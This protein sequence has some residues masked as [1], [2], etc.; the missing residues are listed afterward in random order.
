V[1][2]TTK[3]PM[4]TV[5]KKNGIQ[6]QSPTSI[7]SHMDSIHSP[8]KTRNT[9]INECMKSVKFHLGISLSGKRSTLSAKEKPQFNT[10][11]SPFFPHSSV[12]QHG[13][14]PPYSWD[15]CITH[16]NTPQSV[17]LDW[18]SDQWRIDLYPTTLATDKHPCPQ[19][20]WNLD[21]SRRAA[22][23]LSLTSCGHWDR[24]FAICKHKFILLS[25]VHN[26]HELKCQTLFYSG[27]QRLN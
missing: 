3:F 15:F 26:P 16:N 9:I 1:I 18:M 7:Q 19:Q 5:A 8:H 12:A 24:L 4:T 23:D 14:W 11:L 13:P 21:R 10:L 22:A 6:D 20:D 2:L 25:T 27:S 17:G